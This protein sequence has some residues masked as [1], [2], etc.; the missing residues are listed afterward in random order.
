MG[1]HTR[2]EVPLC[3]SALFPL[4]LSARAGAEGSDGVDFR[5]A[6][7]GEDAEGGG[8]PEMVAEEALVGVLALAGRRH[9]QFPVASLPRRRRLFLWSWWSRHLCSL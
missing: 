8:V 4:H 7:G 5:G 2:V 1:D 3:F 6:E 9:L